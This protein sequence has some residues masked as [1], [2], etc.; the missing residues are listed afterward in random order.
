[1]HYSTITIAI[2]ISVS[3]LLV[4]YLPQAYGV[5]HR[6]DFIITDMGLKN[7]NPF[8]TVMG[9]AGRS[10]SVDMGDESYYAYTF[11][12][13]K[14]VVA[15]T[16]ALGED[17]SKPYYSADGFEVETFEI[18]ACLEDSDLTGKPKFGGKTVEFIPQGFTIQNVSKV[19]ALQVTSDDPDDDCQSGNHIYKIFSSN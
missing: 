12:T 18:G 13:D 9:E 17:E 15:S 5:F 19:Y 14:G 6:E 10:V 7:G 1:M 8:M 3:L 11:V 4:F 16:V 2:T